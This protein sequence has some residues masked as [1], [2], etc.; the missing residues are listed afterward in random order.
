MI[1]HFDVPLTDHSIRINSDLIRIYSA[2]LDQV[3]LNQSAEILSADELARANRL[4]DTKIRDRWIAGRILLRKLLAELLKCDAASIHFTYGEDGKPRL[5]ASNELSF[6]ISH[7]GSQAVFAFSHVLELGID[8]E[9]MHPLS[10]MDRVMQLVFS[11]SEIESVRCLS[12]GNE[13]QA[14]FQI[15]TLKEA[16]LKAIGSGF[17]TPANQFSVISTMDR[18][19]IMEKNKREIRHQGVH[20]SLHPLSIAPGCAAAIAVLN[21]I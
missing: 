5:A 4:Q 19:P 1:P 13:I 14:F 16:F 17:R 11:E 6:N 9:E 7:S 18:Q 15:W 21:R 10:A 2:D 20:A 3:D 8:I 12:G